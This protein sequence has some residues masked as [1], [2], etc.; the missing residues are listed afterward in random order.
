MLLSIGYA[1][2]LLPSGR[3]E[4]G[5]EGEQDDGEGDAAGLPGTLYSQGPAGESK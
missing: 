5:D 2:V 4:A 1:A 3:R